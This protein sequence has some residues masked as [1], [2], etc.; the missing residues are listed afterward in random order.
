MSIN[1]LLHSKSMKKYCDK[2]SIKYEP[3]LRSSPVVT[4]V[5]IQYTDR[6]GR[7]TRPLDNALRVVLKVV[8][9]GMLIAAILGI[10]GILDLSVFIVLPMVV[11]GAI[12]IWWSIDSRQYGEFSYV[13][14]ENTTGSRVL[15][16]MD[17]YDL[18]A[19]SRSK[20]PV[21]M[22]IARLVW[23]ERLIS[24]ETGRIPLG[25][26]AIDR[27]ISACKRSLASKYSRDE[28]LD[29]LARILP[30]DY[31]HVSA[32]F[33]NNDGPVVVY[34]DRAGRSHIGILLR[35]SPS[36]SIAD[37]YSMDRYRCWNEYKSS[38]I[39]RWSE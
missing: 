38:L 16:D 22:D 31:S 6:Q 27:I 5:P 21:V 36:D 17:L 18:M 15:H 24:P 4:D 10:V 3:P 35:R 23:S 29:A 33:S 19:G 34:M 12:A 25:D 9:V 32:V 7:P 37:L 11:L 1:D 28:I 39:D 2:N 13:F 14:I 26:V 8:G 20:D 30:Q